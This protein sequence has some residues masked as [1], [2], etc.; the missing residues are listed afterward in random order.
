MALSQALIVVLHE[1]ATI[2]SLCSRVVW[3]EQGRLVEEGGVDDV[4]ERY[5]AASTASSSEVKL[6]VSTL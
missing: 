6:K 1:M 4:V 5:L 3:L 2:R